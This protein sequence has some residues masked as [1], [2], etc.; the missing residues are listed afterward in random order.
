VVL[1]V[2]GEFMVKED[3]RPLTPGLAQTIV[4]QNTPD[5]PKDP[6]PNTLIKTLGI[7][8]G[9]T[10][11]THKAGIRSD[12]RDIGWKIKQGDIESSPTKTVAVCRDSV[13]TNAS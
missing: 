2:P 9:G 6:A 5:H 8:D 13:L 4:V 3:R 1:R 10:A 11:D 12:L 7:V